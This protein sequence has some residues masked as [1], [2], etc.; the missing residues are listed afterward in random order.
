M[1]GQLATV[2]F[3][4]NEDQCFIQWGHRWMVW[5]RYEKFEIVEV[6][7]VTDHLD[8][9]MHNVRTIGQ[10]RNGDGVILLHVNALFALCKN[11]GRKCC[12]KQS[13][14]S[15]DREVGV[16]FTKS[17]IRRPV[18]WLSILGCTRSR[19]GMCF[20]DENIRDSL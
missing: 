19:Y 9:S 18:S 14:R 13:H 2:E 15:T 16:N 7:D 12:R 10:K 3:A 11:V 1:I 20:I 8:Y 5:L 17:S 4:V 6:T